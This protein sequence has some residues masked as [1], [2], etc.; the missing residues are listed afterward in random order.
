MLQL[1]GDKDSALAPDCGQETL[2]VQ[3]MRAVLQ[4]VPGES[5]LGDSAQGRSI[6]HFHFHFHIHIDSRI[7]SRRRIKLK[8]FRHNNNNSRTEHKASQN[9]RRAIGQDGGSTPLSHETSSPTPSPATSGPHARSI[10]FVFSPTHTTHC[11][12]PG[13]CPERRGD[14]GGRRRRRRRERRRRLCG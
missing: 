1:W 9:G 8:R 13:S 11:P 6:I 5:A 7:S 10:P 14:G 12:T 3:R 4:T 2:S